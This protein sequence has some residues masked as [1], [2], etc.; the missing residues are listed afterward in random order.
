MPPTPDCVSRYLLTGAYIESEMLFA[1]SPD[2]PTCAAEVCPT[3]PHTVADVPPT[4]P[5]TPLSPMSRPAKVEPWP[6]GA[7]LLPPIIALF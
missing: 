5:N 3:S 6:I 4:E 1:E 2:W 7:A